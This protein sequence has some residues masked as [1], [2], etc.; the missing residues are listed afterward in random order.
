M[1][2]N[3]ENRTRMYYVHRLV[4]KAFIPNPHNLATVNHKDLDKSNNNVTNLEWLTQRDNTIH[5]VVNN[6]NIKRGRKVHRY[7]M[8]GEYIDSFDNVSKASRE[9]G[10]NRASIQECCKPFRSNQGHSA[11]GYIWRYAEQEQ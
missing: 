3:G 4:A 7:T 8:G 1:S 6:K 10:I 9:T 5:A 2:N 11:G